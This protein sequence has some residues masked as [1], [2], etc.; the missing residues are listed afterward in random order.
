[1][2]WQG[3]IEHLLCGMEQSNNGI[4]SKADCLFCPQLYVCVNSKHY[5]MFSDTILIIQ[6]PLKAHDLPTK[7]LLGEHLVVVVVAV[8]A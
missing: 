1:M 3:E 6:F 4:K 8:A 2:S 7:L 5:H